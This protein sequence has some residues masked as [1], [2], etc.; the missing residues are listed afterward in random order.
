MKKLK[1]VV[2]DLEKVEED[3]QNLQRENKRLALQMEEFLK[4]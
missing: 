4:K 1:E 2:I 3:K